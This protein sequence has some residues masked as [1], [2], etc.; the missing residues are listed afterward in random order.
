MIRVP[1]AQGQ[2]EETGEDQ[3]TQDAESINLVE[4]FSAEEQSKFANRVI[5]DYDDD[6]KSREEHM[7]Q[8]TR[9][10]ELYAG[11]KKI[12]SWPWQN[13]ANINVPLLTYSILQVHG[14]L[15]D[16]LLPSKGNL[17]SSKPTRDSDENEVDRATRTELFFNWYVQE[18]I[19]EYRPSMDATL[20]QMI[21][22]GSAFR[23]HWWDE[24][25]NRICSEWISIED[26]VVPYSC[27]VTDPSMRNVKRYTLT[28]KMTLFEIQERGEIGDYENT[29]RIKASSA[30]DSKKYDSEFKQAVDETQG[31]QK[32]YERKFLEDEERHVL[33]QHRWLRM[34]KDPNRHPSFD[35]KVH[36]VIAIVDEATRVLL[37]C[38]LREEDDPSDVKKIQ[39]EQEQQAQASQV[40][41]QV[42]GQS[43]V[44]PPPPRK[45]RQRE[46]CFFTHYSC[47]Q[48]EGFY[49]LGLGHFLG[50]LNE[51]MNTVYNQN[52]DRATSNNAG[53][54]F[55]SRQARME[56]GPVAKQPG[57]YVEINIPANQMK[58]IIQPW[59]IIPGDPD[60]RWIIDNIETGANRIS[61]AGDTLSGEPVGSNETA[62]AAM[63][64]FEQAQKQISVL[65]GRTVNYM[66]NDGRVMWRLLSVYLDEK[67]YHDVVDSR[68]MPRSVAIGRGDF[69]A[70]ARVT[71]TAD[72]RLASRSQRI[73]EAQGFLQTVTDPNGPA[74][75]NQNP[76][77]RYAAVQAFLYATDRHEM[78][79][80]LGPPPGPPQPPP[81]KEQ[82]DENAGFLR[83]TDQ[84]VNPQDDDAKHL[85]VMDLFRRDQLGYA[86]LDPTSAKMF[87]Q[88]ERNHLASK[89]EKAKQ[90]D[91]QRRA[92]QAS[93]VDPGSQGS[94]SDGM[95]GQQ[96]VPTAPGVPSAGGAGA[97]SNYA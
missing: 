45:A 96:G 50:P 84:P 54:G 31:T 5:E 88:H 83:G 40:R 21:T 53:G 87:D 10:Y 76:A 18:K 3:G 72:S 12:K 60:T 78:I 44:P 92:A 29:D 57:T 26:M 8:N 55:I 71:P 94:G 32:P 14:R 97:P 93:P 51:A 64:R 69:I 1:L 39:A 13:S 86:K 16:M 17:F 73:D 49:G 95:E 85:L 2:Q 81:P 22:F 47:F 34:P 33:E 68:G 6:V 36:P 90:A 11:L 19:P 89:L 38:V 62:R 56:K 63:N 91:E 59:P 77:I 66:T 25:E 79:Q 24:I 35:G 43:P 75:L 9:W 42:T 37:R 48:G 58:D 52:I 70:D 20:W 4:K 27:K 23:Y 7:R 65:A 74:E 82:W 61:G 41:A 67:E 28:R 46:V 80:L 15:F 30:N